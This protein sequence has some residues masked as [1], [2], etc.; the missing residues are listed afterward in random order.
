MGYF[1]AA[2]ILLAL[3]VKIYSQNKPVK[4]KELL[5]KEPGVV[6]D[7]RTNEEWNSGHYSDAIHL[8]WSNGDFKKA[9]TNLDK[10]KT[11]YLYC[12]AGG[13][14]SQATEYLKSMGFKKVVNL[15]GYS[16]LK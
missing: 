1:I 16:N 11:Y 15:G 3:V 9:S 8:D 6:I 14:S 7:V 13:R 10:N 4:M 5:S 12:A 2:I